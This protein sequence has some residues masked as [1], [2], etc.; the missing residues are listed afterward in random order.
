MTTGKYLVGRTQNLSAAGA[1]VVV[2]RPSLL[3]GGQRLQAAIAWNSNQ[4]VIGSRD[5]FTT[6]VVRSLGLGRTQHVAL[7]FDHPQPLNLTSTA[8]A[9]G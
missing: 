4:A 9:G 5:M 7:Q 6:T 2:D 8:A 3:V 1:L